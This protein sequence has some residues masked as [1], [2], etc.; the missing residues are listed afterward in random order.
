VPGEVGAEPVVA[1]ALADRCARLPFA[2]RLAAELVTS[3]PGVTP[4]ELTAD[5]ADQRL[6]LDRLDAGADPRTAARA[7]FSWSYRRLSPRAARTFRRLGLHPGRD[8]DPHAVAA[9]DATDP[10]R[11]A[12]LLDEL[13]RP[14]WLRRSN[15]PV[16]HARPARAYAAERAAMEDSPAAQHA[17]LTRL[18]DHYLAAAV[19]AIEVAYR[20]TAHARSPPRPPTA[21]PRGP[22]RGRAGQPD[23]RRRAVPGTAGPPT[24]PASPRCWTVC[25]GRRR[26]PAGRAVS[27]TLVRR[28]TDRKARTAGAGRPIAAPS[29]VE[30]YGSARAPQVL[31][32]LGIVA[33]PSF[34]NLWWGRTISHMGDYVPDRLCHV[35]HQRDPLPVVLGV[36][37]AALLLPALVFY[38]L[39]GVASDRA[40][41]RKTV[42]IG[43][44]VGRCLVT[45]A[46]AAAAADRRGMAAGGAGGADRSG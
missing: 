12:H 28:E 22:A 34:R 8:A 35:H 25:T 23:R 6:R 4:A 27:R 18:F 37:T 31:A 43:A 33:Q 13:A 46:V 7:V 9:L 26:R 16:Q 38:L 3:R 21:S 14:I 24:P 19:A 1:R 10:M 5:L 30:G 39:G 32:R 17:A 42:M 36:A 15:R 40:A 45:A 29:P 41:A 11:A 2:L 20:T 44:D